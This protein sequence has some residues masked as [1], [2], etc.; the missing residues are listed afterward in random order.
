MWLIS[1]SGKEWERSRLQLAAK[2]ANIELQF[3]DP[4]K[5]V[6]IVSNQQT[7]FYIDGK[8]LT[9]PQFVLNWLG[10][11][12]SEVVKQI[13]CGLPDAKFINLPSE[14]DLLTNKFTFQIS[15]N[16]KVVDSIKLFS[17]E[18]LN[19]LNVIEQKISY[20]LILKGDVGSL[21][22]GVYKIENREN[23]L[24]VGEVI[25]LLDKKYKLHIEQ[26]IDY[27]C[28][29][30]MLIIGEEYWLMNRVN[31][32]DFRA[33]IALGAVP[34]MIESN[35]LY[36]QIFKLVK[37]NYQSQI[38]GVDLLVKGEEIYI[39]EINIS[40]NFKGIQTLTNVDIAR[41]IIKLASKM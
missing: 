39:C 18:I 37:A 21:G 1:N 7:E 28:D 30:R 6:I 16:L 5:L 3:I 36:E 26:F 41:K 31:T 27:D 11:S 17:D 4:S 14:I 25:S 10:C 15:T 23:L 9:K 34:T 20:P 12:S 13:Y 38:L 2:R 33:N 22:Y 29:V 32:D 35:P 24:Q 19:N 8:K 40:P